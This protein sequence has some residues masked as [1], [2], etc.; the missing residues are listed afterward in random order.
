MKNKEKEGIANHYQI[1]K[2]KFSRW[3]RFYDLIEFFPQAKRL[4][5]VVVDSIDKDGNILDLCCGTGTVAIRIAKSRPLSN[6]FG[7]DLSIEMLRV[8][9]KKSEGLKNIFFFGGMAQKI[10]FPESYFDFVIISF[11]LHEMPKQMRNTALKETFRTL[12]NRGKIIILDLRKVY[13]WFKYP[14]F[15][16]LKLLEPPYVLEFIKEDLKETLKETGF[17]SIKEEY[18][19]ATRL[20]I[21]EKTTKGM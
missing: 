8:A 10:S 20:I 21:G 15:L 3:A 19:G 7:L 2:K 6:V 14:L 18:I 16:Y 5:K 11:S 4:R 9:R 13:N 12:K 1:M 17:S